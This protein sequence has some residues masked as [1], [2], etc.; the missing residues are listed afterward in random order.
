MRPRHALAT[1]GAVPTVHFR[2]VGYTLRFDTIATAT[3][4]RTTVHTFLRLAIV[5]D[6]MRLYL[7]MCT[8]CN[9]GGRP[10]QVREGGEHDRAVGLQME[11]ELMP[12]LYL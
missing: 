10:G 11:E 9:L 7:Y 8:G 12:A 1:Y 4:D 3:G 5:S 6:A 2:P